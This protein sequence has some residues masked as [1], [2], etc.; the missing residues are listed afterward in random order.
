MLYIVAIHDMSKLR[1]RA[2]FLAGRPVG[3]VIAIG[4]IDRIDHMDMAI[5]LRLNENGHVC[6]SDDWTLN[7]LARVIPYHCGKRA[8]P[9]AAAPTTS[10]RISLPSRANASDAARWDT[11]FPI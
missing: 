5:D 6:R 11:W 1:G 8:S 2:D 9:G 4:K 3:D 7:Q 10:F